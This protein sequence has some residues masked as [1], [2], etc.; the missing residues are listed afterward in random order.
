MGLCWMPGVSG[1]GDGGTVG[2]EGLGVGA[3]WACLIVC[4]W[5]P[6][7]FSRAATLIWA[8]IWGWTAL[9]MAG[10]AAALAGGPEAE[11][12]GVGWA[13][14]TAASAVVA[15]LVWSV[16]Q[17]DSKRSAA[18]DG[19][20]GAPNGLSAGAFGH[21]GW[22]VVGGLGLLMV[23]SATAWTALWLLSPSPEPDAPQAPPGPLVVGFAVSMGL[24]LGVVVTGLWWRTMVGRDV[25]FWRVLW[26]ATIPRLLL[27][28]A[29]GPQSG[30]RIWAPIYL[31]LA[32]SQLLLTCR[33]PGTGTEVHGRTEEGG[34]CGDRDGEEGETPARAPV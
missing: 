21:V 22:W 24:V 29:A 4:I 2:W 9:I 1:A 33:E 30:W 5:L 31:A 19:A 17:A 23:L 12:T 3:S 15:C 8:V 28:P 32:A 6:G 34:G 13:M 20:E 18:A 16:V 14:G 7:Q 25:L 10:L 11:P 27:M 26:A